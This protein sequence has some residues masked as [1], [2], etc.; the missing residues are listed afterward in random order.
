MKN[1]AATLIDAG[2]LIAVFNRNDDYYAD[3]V[4][5]YRA[6]KR[7]FLTTLAVLAE[8]MY[9]L[10]ARAGWYGQ[11]LLWRM[12]L[13]GDLVVEHLSPAELVRMSELMGK[14]RDRPMDFADASLVAVAE[15]LGLER[16]FTVDRR[17]FSV[18]RLH[19]KQPFTIIGP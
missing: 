15:R 2:P 14:Y 12:M 11:E 10:G 17:D 4:R 16:V 18:Y 5:V 8:A 3:C 19:G 13:H 1:T 9:T 7:P 6:L